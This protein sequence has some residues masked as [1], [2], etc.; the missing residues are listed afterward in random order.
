MRT[1]FVRRG[2]LWVRV[3]KGLQREN[4]GKKI[5]AFFQYLA[6]TA[7]WIRT[8][9]LL[10]HSRLPKWSEVVHAGPMRLTPIRKI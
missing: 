1:N 10:I 5:D 9:D 6:G 8:T 4:H 3:E 2:P 7:G